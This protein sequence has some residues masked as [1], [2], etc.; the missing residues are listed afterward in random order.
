[1]VGAGKGAKE[2][3]GKKRKQVSEHERTYSKLS[4]ETVD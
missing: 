3:I 2:G 4:Y 1:M